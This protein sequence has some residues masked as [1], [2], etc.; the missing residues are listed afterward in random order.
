MNTSGTVLC[1]GCV[2]HV[3]REGT[4]NASFCLHTH[5]SF[6]TTTT[7]KWSLAYRLNQRTQTTLRITSMCSILLSIPD[8]LQVLGGFFVLS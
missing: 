7:A 5:C 1:H 2:L 8:D 3:R 4:S 6:K